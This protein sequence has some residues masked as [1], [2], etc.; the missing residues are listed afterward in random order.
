LIPAAKTDRRSGVQGWGAWEVAAR[1]SY[2]NVTDADI[3][4]GR[5]TDLTLGV[6]WYWNPNAKLQFNY[7]HAFARAVAA[8]PTNADIFALRAS[9]DF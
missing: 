1:V 6:N 2:V 5:L 8:G 3:A 9:V 7:I 4:G